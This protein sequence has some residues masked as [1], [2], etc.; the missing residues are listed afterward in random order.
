MNTTLQADDTYLMMSDLN[1]MSLQNQINI[2]KTLI[3]G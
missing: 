1:L 2:E 3:F